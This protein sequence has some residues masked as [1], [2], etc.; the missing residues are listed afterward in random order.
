LE[1]GYCKKKKKKKIGYCVDV[2]AIFEH[3]VALF[4]SVR[5]EAHWLF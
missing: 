1:L 2:L 3:I 4:T 5:I